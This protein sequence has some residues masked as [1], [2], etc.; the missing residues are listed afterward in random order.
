MRKT[1]VSLKEFPIPVTTRHKDRR[2]R[3][4]KCGS[5]ASHEAVFKV[6]GA[7]LVEW[8]CTLHVKGLK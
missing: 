4:V 6:E 2:K 8:Y 5:L 1:L 7:S 3:C